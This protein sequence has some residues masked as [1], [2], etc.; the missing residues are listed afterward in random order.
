MRPSDAAIIAAAGQAA[1]RDSPDSHHV[2]HTATAGMTNAR[3]WISDFGET[4][5]IASM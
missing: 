4:S 2:Q 5:T 1:V 3:W